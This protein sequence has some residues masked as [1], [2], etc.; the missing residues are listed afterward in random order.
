ML[1]TAQ[2]RNYFTPDNHPEKGEWYWAD[3]DAMAG[4]AGGGEAGIQPV[5]IEEVFGT[6]H[7]TVC[8]YLSNIPPE[9]H[10][11]EASSRLARGFPIGRSPSVDVRN[12]H[13]SYIVTW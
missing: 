9:G 1:R 4:F 2:V 10:A 3:I 13:V 12:S 6:H 8:I 7:H 11:G 5:F